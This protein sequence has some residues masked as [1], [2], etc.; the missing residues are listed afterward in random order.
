[1]SWQQ[2]ADVDEHAAFDVRPVE[3]DKNKGGSQGAGKLLMSATWP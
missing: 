1:M 2:L 3:N